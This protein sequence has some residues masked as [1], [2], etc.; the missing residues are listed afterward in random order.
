M[1]PTI[2][3]AF[4]EK[5][6]IAPPTVVSSGPRHAILYAIFPLHIVILTFFYLESSRYLP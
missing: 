1:A 4:R 5:S 3:H 6:A 2:P